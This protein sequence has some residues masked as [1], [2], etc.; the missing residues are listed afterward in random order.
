MSTSETDGEILFDA[1]Q[2]GA[3]RAVDTVLWRDAVNTALHKADQAAQVR[4]C[5]VAPSEAAW[6]HEHARWQQ[7]YGD[8]ID[9]AMR[10]GT[11]ESPAWYYF[12]LRAVYAPKLRAD[13]RG[14]SLRVRLAG[15]TS[16]EDS[17]MDFAIAVMP[18]R[19]ASAFGWSGAAPGEGTPWPVAI[20]TFTGITSPTPA[21]LTPDDSSDVLSISRELVEWGARLESAWP[22][23]TD[24]GGAPTLV[25]APTLSIM[26]LGQ[27]RG[28]LGR[29]RLYAAY[30]AEYVG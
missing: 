23:L 24:L 19:A 20:K 18:G 7:I 29:P 5:W 12:G 9:G 6:S 25:I 26:V 28:D 2:L 21:W 8:G 30:A 11:D 17:A 15:C 3:D 16:V 14:Y 13:E 22:T 4:M 10:T 27:R 1:S